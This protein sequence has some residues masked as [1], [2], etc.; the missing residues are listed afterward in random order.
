MGESMIDLVESGSREAAA[1]RKLGT[2]VALSATALIV[3]AFTLISESNVGLS[4]GWDE[5]AYLASARLVSQGL[6]LFE[7]VF[8]SQPPVFLEILGCAFR[9][10]G[11]TGESGARVSSAFGVLSLLAFAWIAGRLLG[12]TAAPVAVL[13][14]LSKLFFDQA[15]TVE[16]EIP[17]LGLALLSLAILCPPGGRS[18]AALAG[19]GVCF[20]LAVL[21]KLWVAPYALPVLFLLAI[22]P[23][24]SPEGCWR[25]LRGSA[26][27]V[28][29]RLVPFGLAGVLT[30][31]VVMSRYDLWSVY[32]QAV[33][34]HWIA[35]EIRVET[36]GRAGWDVLARAARRDSFVQL[37]ALVGLV[38][39]ARRD[40]L[41]AGWLGLW[42]AA[43]AAF[44]LHHTPVFNRH[45]LLMGP[46]LALLAAALVPA[47]AAAARRQAWAW[48]EPAFAALLGLLLILRPSFGKGVFHWTAPVMTQLPAQFVPDPA[49]DEAVR[50]IRE[51][52]RPEDLVVSDAPLLPFLAGRN[53]PPRLVDTS[54]T[55]VM[56]G[57]LTADEAITHTSSA[58]LVVLWVDKL[59]R[60]PGYRAWVRAHYRRVRKW[61]G[62][63]VRREL[64][65]ANEPSPGVTSPETPPR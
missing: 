51:L 65:V 10:F 44:L 47:V 28:F 30:A 61:E 1:R 60:L 8:S 29:R 42:A 40:K 11:D 45:A 2:A 20:S 31:V 6:P 36:W 46:P 48:A 52:S 33:R 12:V 18:P 27:A 58:R 7:A 32:D 63:E 3:V 26:D 56:S 64:Y 13:A 37:L 19:A 41:A 16:A 24:P 55:R 25:F 22:D 23:E 38:T 39:L 35:R 9:I 59:D 53:L 43:S 17:A 62:G 5:G 14:L 49:Q 54:G 21:C 34:F 50:L 15:I 4:Y 57:H